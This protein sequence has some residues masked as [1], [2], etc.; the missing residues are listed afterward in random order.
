MVVDALH[1]ARGPLAEP[2]PTRGVRAVAVLLERPAGPSVHRWLRAH[3]APGPEVRTWVVR[4][5]PRSERGGL[6]DPRWLEELDG[7]AEAL[8]APRAERRTVVGA[9]DAAA[10]VLDDGATLFVVVDGP[11]GT[12][13]G[14][15]WAVRQA[16][17]STLI[18]PGEEASLAERPRAVFVARDP[19]EVLQVAAWTPLLAPGVEVALRG[20]V[21]PASEAPGRVLAELTALQ[22]AL[23]ATRADLRAA[24]RTATA[25]CG[26]EEDPAGADATLVVRMARRGL[27]RRLLPGPD[28]RACRHARLLVAP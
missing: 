24:G 11:R 7:V 19:A 28:A 25:A 6:P 14:A 2:A 12:T 18:I 5:A 13:R 21:A 3:L 1:P 9:F 10:G 8:S 17:G 27:L 4:V 22:A 20:V 15:D 26:L 16:R 23:D